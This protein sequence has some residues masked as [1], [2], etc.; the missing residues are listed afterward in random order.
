MR[1]VTYLWLRLSRGASAVG[2]ECS[3]TCGYAAEWTAEPEG[4]SRLEAT[5]V[6]QSIVQKSLLFDH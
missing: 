1:I 6:P 4:V 3:H 5:G 2:G